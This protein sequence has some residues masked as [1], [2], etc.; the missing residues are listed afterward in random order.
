MVVRMGF[1]T[2]KK[3]CFIYVSM[4]VRAI[5]PFLRMCRDDAALEYVPVIFQSVAAPMVKY[6]PSH[7]PDHG[8]RTLCFDVTSTSYSRR[9]FGLFRFFPPVST[10][11]TFSSIA[12]YLSYFHFFLRFTFCCIFCFCF[13]FFLLLLLLLPPPLGGGNWGGNTDWPLRR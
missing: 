2:K 4:K 11:V 5:S 6:L 10:V 12:L 1:R 3:L 8:S 13:F 7:Q 9:R